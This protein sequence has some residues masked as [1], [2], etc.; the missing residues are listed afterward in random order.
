MLTLDALKKWNDDY[1][2]NNVF[3]HKMSFPFLHNFNLKNKWKK[4]MKKTTLGPSFHLGSPNPELS[5]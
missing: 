5:F 3:N 1:A 4:T 2:I